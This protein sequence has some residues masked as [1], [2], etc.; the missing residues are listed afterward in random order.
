[1]SAR[2]EILGRVRDALAEVSPA[3]AVPAAP[4]APPPSSSAP[5]TAASARAAASRRP[6]A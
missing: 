2:D 3:V 6:S 5:L 1:M 4:R